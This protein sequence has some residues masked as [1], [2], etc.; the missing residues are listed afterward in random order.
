MSEELQKQ[1]EVVEQEVQQND[2]PGIPVPGEVSKAAPKGWM[3]KEDWVAAGRDPDD[4]VSEKEYQARQSF[5]DKIEELK[6]ENR[7]TKRAL[8][9]LKQHYD[10]VRETEFKRALSALQSAKKVA[11]EEGDADKVVEIDEAIAQHRDAIR[12]QRHRAASELTPEQEEIVQQ[13]GKWVEQNEW[14]KKDADMQIAA[15]AAAAS[16]R[17]A[18]PDASPSDVLEYAK[19][20]VKRQFPTK[21]G[22]PATRRAPAV[23]GEGRPPARNNSNEYELSD[24]ERTVMNRLVKSG[25]LTKEQYIK[26]LKA[27]KGVK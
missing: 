25:V 8:Q 21:F 16:Y 12:E 26:D 27:I 4:W 17:A 2:D 5:F 13:F 20:A 1:D 7:G 14:Y 24:E 23:E 22:N 9:A 19:N 3:S 15:N 11:L 18:N 6:R 10:Q